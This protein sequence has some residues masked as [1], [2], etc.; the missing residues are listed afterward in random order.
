MCPFARSVKYVIA[1]Y[2]TYSWLK[3]QAGDSLWADCIKQDVD[4]QLAAKGWTKVDGNRNATVAA[5]QSTHD[6]QTLEIFGDLP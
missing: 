6:Q 2:N 3:V 1:Q 5:F 4:A